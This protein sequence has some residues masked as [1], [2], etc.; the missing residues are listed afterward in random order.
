[1]KKKGTSVSLWSNP[2]RIWNESMIQ[3]CHD[4]VFQLQPMFEHSLG[5]SYCTSFSGHSI[6]P[7][8]IHG[9]PSV[10]CIKCIFENNLRDLIMIMIT[11]LR[12]FNPKATD[13]IYT[14]KLLTGVRSDPATPFWLSNLYFSSNLLQI[15][16]K[17]L[18]ILFSITCM[19]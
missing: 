10:H 3:S 17:T 6:G 15:K 13:L 5:S 14:L 12:L 16:T 19:Q 9:L 2:P 8:D 18:V 7:Q 11:Q 1:M 4:Q